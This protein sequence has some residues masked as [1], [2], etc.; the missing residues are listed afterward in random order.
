[1]SIFNSTDTVGDRVIIVTASDFQFFLQRGVRKI[2]IVESPQQNV[3]FNNFL[4][5]GNKLSSKS[6]ISTKEMSEIETLNKALEASKVEIEALNKTMEE[7][8]IDLDAM[9]NDLMA[10]KTKIKALI[11]ELNAA[12][13]E[14][15]ALKQE[16]SN[17][18]EIKKDL[19]DAKNDLEVL[20]K[21]FEKV[22]HSMQTTTPSEENISENASQTADAPSTEVEIGINE[23]DD[24]LSL[25]PSNITEDHEIIQ[26]IDC[27]EA[28]NDIS[29]LETPSTENN[30]N[31]ES[32][33]P[34]EV[35]NGLC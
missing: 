10:E 25:N 29:N 19:E 23:K 3:W 33:V 35:E 32:G 30:D 11:E 28:E 2:F 21:D 13:M 1:M 4:N 15:K 8:N 17:I 26:E 20:K 5:D 7:R 31:D 12:K 18:N 34:A 14:M 24:I 22:K 9:K 16:A 27:N 6:D